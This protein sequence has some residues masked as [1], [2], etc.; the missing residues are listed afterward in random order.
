MVM[1][2]VS[3]AKK[4]EKEKRK[5]KKPS[6]EGRVRVEPITRAMK[7][8]HCGSRFVWG[9]DTEGISPLLPGNTSQSHAGGKRTRNGGRNS[10]SDVLVVA[11]LPPT[12]NSGNPPRCKRT[13]RIDTSPSPSSTPPAPLL[14]LRL[15]HV[16][17]RAPI[18]V[19]TPHTHATPAH[20]ASGRTS[21]PLQESNHH[22][23]P[24]VDTICTRPRSEPENTAGAGRGS[25]CAVM[26]SRTSSI[27]FATHTIITI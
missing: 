4:G 9:H 23:H 21:T 15:H 13:A 26:T 27:S 14:L 8:T 12:L 1:R 22:H 5:K 16:P 18:P 6:R 3:L 25:G 7:V 2:W 10:P 17:T 20:C 19:T 11:A 24:A